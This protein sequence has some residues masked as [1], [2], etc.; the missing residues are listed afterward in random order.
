[1]LAAGAGDQRLVEHLLQNSADLSL[2]DEQFGETALVRAADRGDLATV[3]LLL[4]QG[5]AGFQ[6]LMVQRPRLGP[7][8]DGCTALH[9][10]ASHGFREICDCL[11]GVGADANAMDR[12]GRMPLH[13]AVEAD[14]L[15]VVN[16]LLSFG[17]APSGQDQEGLSPLHLAAMR[18]RDAIA[19]LLLRYQA[20]VHLGC[21]S[22]RMPT[23]AAAAK[24]H[25]T[26]CRLLLRQRAEPNV[27][28]ATGETPFSLAFREARVGCCRALL[29][30][31]AEVLAVDS[32]R[33]TPPYTELNPR[34]VLLG[35]GTM[36]PDDTLQDALC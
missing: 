5:S 10:A 29:D 22:G 14:H 20:D 25:D 16:V 30:A 15:E 8:G 3:Q 23:H 19:E 2:A 7:L 27:A 34:E 36:Q 1:V 21:R 31:R 35:G 26:L 6:T 33:W 17:A 4:T 13:G 11:L 24:G 28:D 12:L 18:G 9:L 32:Q